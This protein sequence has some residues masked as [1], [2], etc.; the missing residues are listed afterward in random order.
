MIDIGTALGRLR[1]L[2]SAYRIPLTLCIRVT[3]AAAL[4]LFL[5]QAL[6]FPVFLWVVLTAVVLTQVSF[7]RSLKA[8]IDYLIGTLAGVIFAGAVGAL[9]WPTDEIS[10]VVA[11]VLAVAPV[12]FIGAIRPAFTVAP[13]TA[14]LV[15]LS[16]ALTHLTPIASAYYRLLE[17]LLG[18]GTALAVSFL[19]FPQRAHDLTIEAAAEMLDLLSRSLREL[20]AGFTGRLSVNEIDSIQNRIGERL[21]NLENISAEARHEQATYLVAGQGP[22][23]APLL[24]TLLRLRHDLII[25]GRAAIEPLPEAIQ[26]QVGPLLEEL[27]DKA[28]DYLHESAI[29]IQARRKPPPLDA[30]ESAM[31]TFAAKLD[32]LREQGLIYS[33]PGD[34][35]ERLFAL[36][37]AIEQLKKNFKDLQRCGAE[38]AQRSIPPLGKATK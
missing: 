28:S 37:F 23:L 12:A 13:F 18:G 5:S 3:A 7:G 38:S 27:A 20:I 17:V 34:M 19:I 16:P 8:T 32:A 26:R 6:H 11:L 30:V 22:E 25:I 21:S 14:V 10:L 33:L 15:I 9:I 35:M 29:C 1:G 24:R 36:A 4:S 31:N 2:L